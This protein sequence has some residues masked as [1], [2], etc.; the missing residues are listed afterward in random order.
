MPRN[1]LG[2]LEVE[3]RKARALLEGNATEGEIDVSETWRLLR[4]GR[5]EAAALCEL[6]SIWGLRCRGLWVGLKIRA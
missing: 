6:G 1:T 2:E 3:L 4:E 5:D